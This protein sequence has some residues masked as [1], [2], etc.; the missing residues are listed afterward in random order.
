[1]SDEAT[2]QR[3]EISESSIAKL[4]GSLATIAPLVLAGLQ[5][6]NDPSNFV[7]LLICGLLFV[8]IMLWR[9]TQQTVREL[10]AEVVLLRTAMQKEKSLHDAYKAITNVTTLNMFARINQLSGLRDAGSIAW[11]KD[12]G[13]SVYV[14]PPRQDPPDGSFKRAGDPKVVVASA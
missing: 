11:D 12:T 10:K 13:A 4:L 2:E 14:P 6:L 9:T 3:I 7:G 1:M 8:V 5:Y